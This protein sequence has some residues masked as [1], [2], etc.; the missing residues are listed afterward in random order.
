[1]GSRLSELVYISHLLF[2]DDTL[3]FCGANSDH[4]H[5]LRIL[6]VCFEV[7]SGLK[8]NLANLVSVPMGNVD[9]LAISAKCYTF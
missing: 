3:V 1:M 4:L 9:E 7:V 2:V 5:S 6:F 8:V